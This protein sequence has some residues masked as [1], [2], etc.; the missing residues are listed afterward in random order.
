MHITTKVYNTT[1]LEY[2]QIFMRYY[3]KRSWWM[4]LVL[5]G[6]SLRN[7]YEYQDYFVSSIIVIFLLL[8]QFA[9]WRRLGAA[10]NKAIF[11]AKSFSFENGMI[12]AQLPDGQQ[13]QLPFLKLYHIIQEKNYYLLFVNKSAFYYLPKSVFSSEE[14]FKHLIKLLKP[15]ADE[16]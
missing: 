5:F 14:D 12:T 11:T 1:K 3:F 6:L 13:T 10:A 7:I 15:S 16:H 2:F 4:I 9:I 8:F